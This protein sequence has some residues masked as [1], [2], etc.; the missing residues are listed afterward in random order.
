MRR[1]FFICIFYSLTLF[2]VIQISNSLFYDV[3]CFRYGADL[4]VV[5]SYQQNNISERLAQEKLSSVPES[6]FWLGLSSLDGLSTNQLE[7]ASGSLVPQYA[8][9]KNGN[10]TV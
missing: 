10:A 1:L 7:A 5:E 8:G 9:K 4:V 3:A 6:A 2:R